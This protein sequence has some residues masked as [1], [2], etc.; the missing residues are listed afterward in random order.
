MT[1]NFNSIPNFLVQSRS[2]VDNLNKYNSLKSEF[3]QCI[4]LDGEFNQITIKQ[5]ST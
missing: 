3:N 1:E 5:D 4:Y 2:G